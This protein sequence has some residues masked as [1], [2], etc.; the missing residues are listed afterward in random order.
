MVEKTKRRRLYGL[1]RKDVRRSA[2]FAMKIL[3]TGGNGQ[4]GRELAKQLQGI[5]FLATS[6]TSMDITDRQTTIAVISGYQP[7]MVIHCAAYTKVDEAETNADLAYEVNGGGTENVAMACRQCGAK[8]VY[9][10]TDYVFDGAFGRPYTESDQPNPISIYGQSKLSGEIVAKEILDKLFIVRTSWLYGDGTNFVRTVLRLAQEKTELKIVADQ[11]GCPTYTADLAK[12]IL[13][14]AHTEQYGLYHATN[15][16]VTTW[17][18]LAKT[19]LLLA[20][21][22][23]I[24][25]LPIST[26]ELDRPARR[27]AYSALDT[28]KLSHTIGTVMRPWPAALQE[29]LVTQRC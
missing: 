15:T 21:K 12:V 18:D 29:Y 5:D 6:T 17:F 22:N 4:L 3:L 26:R 25:V 10:S 13:Q 27:P 1:P 2:L 11:S 24:R 8:M 20:G 19:V 9:T 16:G 14:L 28:T 7:D 23:S